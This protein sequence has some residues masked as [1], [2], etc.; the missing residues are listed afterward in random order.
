MDKRFFLALF[1]SL[2]AIAISQLLFPPSKPIP[3]NRL[4]ADSSAA[5]PAA[6]TTA[7]L[8]P[9]T[10]STTTSRTDV[11]SVPATA[12]ASTSSLAGITAETT[13]V[14]TPK[15]SY[16]FSNVGA[17]PVSIVMRDYVN[18][19]TSGGLV[20]LAPQGLPLLG[21]KLV[22]PN[23]T[24]DLSQTPFVLSRSKGPTGQDILTYNA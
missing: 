4:T 13:L 2:I 18:R 5:S 21:Y 16:R 6:S 10:S 24:A 3:A 8:A 17:A 14:S 22:T 11:A 9:S 19:S 1:L 15:V 12:S 20:D 23:D 7:R